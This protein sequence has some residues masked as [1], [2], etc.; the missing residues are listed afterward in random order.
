M[1]KKIVFSFYL[2]EIGKN[3]KYFLTTIIYI[4]TKNN[5]VSIPIV[6][7]LCKPAI[8]TDSQASLSSLL[9][10]YKDGPPPVSIGEILTKS[11]RLKESLRE[12]LQECHAEFSP[13][14]NEIKQHAYSLRELEIRINELNVESRNKACWS[15]KFSFMF[16]YLIDILPFTG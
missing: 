14:A 8:M 9:Q 7:F 16:K 11:S 2:L 6:S 1:I 4:C 15:L 10:E 3:I 13:V 5:F 12:T